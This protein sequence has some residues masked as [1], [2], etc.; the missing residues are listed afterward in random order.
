MSMNQK[1]VVNSIGSLVVF[2]AQWLISVFLI[3]TSGFEDAGIFSLA[4]SISNVFSFFANY[5]IRNY[6]ISDIR[7]EYGQNQYFHARII[8]V[9][10]SFIFCILYLQTASGYERETKYAILIY[11]AYSNINV[12][13]DVMLGSLQIRGRLDVNGYSNILR[14]IVC[15]TAFAAAYRMKNLLLSLGA[16]ATADFVMTMACDVRLY[17]KLE[18]KIRLPEKRDIRAAGG[19]L[20][21]CFWLMLSNMFPIITTAVPRRKIQLLCGEEALGIF[22]G[23]FNPTVLITTLAPALILSVIPLITDCWNRKEKKK[24]ISV[25][26]K[27]YLLCALITAA[28]EI[29]ALICGK[30]VMKLVFGESILPYYNLLYWA[31]AV[32]GINAMTSCGPAVLIPMR[33]NRGG[34]AAALLSMLYTVC[35]S[36]RLIRM[37]DL[38]G[39]VYALLSAYLIQVLIQAGAIIYYMKKKEED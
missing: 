39:A 11:L 4:M 7:K 8:T 18:G 29:M 34:A 12:I 31:I 10:C 23:I 14:G 38:K 1:A 21:C 37:Y 32:T 16:M 2:F 5:N 35:C 20:K 13:S 30:P 27:C 3:R 26:C 19:I 33:T 36:G 15:F 25:V 22:S 6:Q 24:F 17:R 9:L 28:A